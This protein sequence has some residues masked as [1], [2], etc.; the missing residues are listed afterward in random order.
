M[1]R[2]ALSSVD[3]GTMLLDTSPAE[4][5][6]RSFATLAGR[7]SIVLNVSFFFIF[8]LFLLDGMM[9]Y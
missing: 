5:E 2:A 8:R 9:Q 4:S 6:G 3:L 1:E 7:A